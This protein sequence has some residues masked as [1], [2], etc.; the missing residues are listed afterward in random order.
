M[1]AR[2]I[3]H[4]WLYLAVIVATTGW[5]GLHAS[6]VDIERDNESLSTLEPDQR[7]AADE[8]R[9]TFGSDDDLIIA[10]GDDQLLSAAGLARIEH[11]TAAIGAIDGVAHVF[12]LTNAKQLVPGPD[13]AM[14]APLVQPPWDAPEE[15]AAAAH[16]LDR[17][18]D[19]TGLLISADRRTAGLLVELELHDSDP[20]HRERV[21]RAV[22]ALLARQQQPDISLHLS[23]MAV[24]VYDVGELVRRDQATLVPIAIAVLGLVLALF[25]RRPIGV[26]LPLAV[27][28]VSLVWTLGLYGLA[29]L[30]V[31]AITALLPPILMVLAITVSVHLVQ[32]W[33]RP[34]EAKDDRLARIG[35]VVRRLAFPCFF[36]ALTTGMGFASLAMSNMPA[37]R[38]FGV[39]AAIGVAISFAMAMTLIPVGLSFLAPPAATTV[40]RRGMLDRLLVASSELV[41][42][43]PKAI[44]I[45][46]ACITGLSLLGLPHIRNNTDLVRFLKSDAPLYR[47]TMYIDRHLTGA[48]SVELIVRRHD[49]APMIGVDDV[50]R[51]EALEQEARAQPNVTNVMSVLPLLRQIERAERSGDDLTLPQNDADTAYA[52]DLLEAVA[53]EQPLVGKVIAADSTAARLSLRV[54]AIGTAAAEPMITHLRR[55]GAEILG[56]D[57]RLDVGGA[58]VQVVQDSNR[59]VVAQA[60]SFGM[61]ML[62]V[63]LAIGL[64]FRSPRLTLLSVIP[65]TA[66]IL[67]TGGLM[68]A[69]GIDLSTGTVMIASAVLGLVVDDTIHYL[70][71][72]GRVYR[73]DRA[74]AIRATSSSIGRSLVLNNV[75]LV[76]GFWVGCF[77]S[78][79]PTIYFSL[80]SGVTMMAGLLCDL[81]VTPLCL[82]TFDKRRPHP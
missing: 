48:N 4:R 27:T 68:G 21:I 30:R 12:S 42:R 73:G 45:A 82:L 64:L 8:R 46:F 58:F 32:A 36:C 31:N 2:L 24:Q 35:G 81:L 69:F 29:G 77:G 25:F 28:G 14:E 54:H 70:T 52:F 76:L 57:Y 26:L 1:L 41:V 33:L 49:G 6:R 17:N 11:L 65:N 55:R 47:D 39:F 59:L 3:R 10:V 18:P 79:K 40:P 50:R 37:V 19:Y 51:L 80:F 20:L 56:P 63:F 61:A 66:P 43:Y 62:L 16:A 53:A 71:Q 38:Q 72:Y 60:K 15:I 23:G 5:L 7:H 75:I 44:W 22:R 13:G 9:R 74:A 34:E 78:F 67:W